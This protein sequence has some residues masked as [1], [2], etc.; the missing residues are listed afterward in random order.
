MQISTIAGNKS[1]SRSFSSILKRRSSDLPNYVNTVRSAPNVTSTDSRSANK[2]RVNLMN[3]SVNFPEKEAV[4]PLQ[5][6]I[7]NCRIIANI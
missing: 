5:S 4:D 3:G 2:S 1:N 6:N 7:G